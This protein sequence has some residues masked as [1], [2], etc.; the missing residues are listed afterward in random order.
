MAIIAAISVTISCQQTPLHLAASNG[1]DYTVECLIKKGA[2]INIK[3]KTGVRET[4]LLI[5]V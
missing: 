2:N 1:H 5:A 3:D 4:I